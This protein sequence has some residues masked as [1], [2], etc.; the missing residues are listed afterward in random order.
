MVDNVFLTQQLVRSYGRSTATPRCMLMV[1]VRKVFDTLT[2]SFL[3]EVLT[4]FGFPKIFI[5]WI[6]QCVTTAAYSIS[7]NGSLH[8]FF[9]GKRGIQ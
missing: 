8:G 9:P 7:F 2:W 6:M 5:N 4:G 3:Q 1:D